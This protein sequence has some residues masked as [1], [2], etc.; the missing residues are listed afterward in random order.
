MIK[1]LTRRSFVVGASLATCAFAAGTA[2]AD[3][4]APEGAPDAGGPGEGGAPGAGGPG[5]MGS[6]DPIDLTG[7]LALKQYVF[8]ASQGEVTDG[9]VSCECFGAY[10]E[11]DGVRFAPAS[12]DGAI[13]V[14]L[15]AA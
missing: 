9:T 1:N 8:V 12:F 11:G 4:A 6:A 13:E 10:G 2:L 15:D 14:Y 5:G 7:M 3:A